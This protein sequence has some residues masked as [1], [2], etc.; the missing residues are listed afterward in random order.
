MKFSILFIWRDVQ[1]T[2]NIFDS[3]E[4]PF[5]LMWKDALESRSQRDLLGSEKPKEE[6]TPVDEDASL[7]RGWRTY[8]SYVN[9]MFPIDEFCVVSTSPDFV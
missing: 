9:D 6:D 5:D 4:L 3:L 1:S 7:S 8:T 2:V